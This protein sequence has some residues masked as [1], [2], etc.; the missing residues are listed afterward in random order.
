MF[1]CYRMNTM[2]LFQPFQIFIY[3]CYICQLVAPICIVSNCLWLKV[4]GV[5][6]ELSQYT[7]W[8]SHWTSYLQKTCLM[9]RLINA[10]FSLCSDAKINVN[11]ASYLL[12]HRLALAH[13]IGFKGNKRKSGKDGTF[14]SVRW[15]IST[16]IDDLCQWQRSE[17]KSIFRSLTGT[18][19]T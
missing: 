10:R 8:M 16:R 17:R 3:N 1:L 5:S 18:H 7:H 14:V 6:T 4:W 13:S 2:S 15:I 19:V 12:R 11:V 9:E